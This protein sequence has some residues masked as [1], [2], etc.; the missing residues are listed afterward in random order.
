MVSAIAFVAPKPGAPFECRSVELDEVRPHEVL[1]DI[2]A[3]GIC[4]TDIAVQQGKL[5]MRLPGILGHEGAGVVRMVGSEVKDVQPGDHVV[6]SYNSCG[7]CRSCKGEKPYQC[8]NAE[9]M[10]FGGSRPDGSQTVTSDSETI[11]T[12]FFGQSSFC[13]PAIVQEASC[14]K[15]DKSLPLKVICALG[16]GFQTGTGAVYNVVDPQQRN[17]RHIAIFG[18][19]AVGCAAIMAASHL[20]TSSSAAP[21]FEIIA[22]DINDSRLELAKELGATRVIN[23]RQGTAREAIMEITNNEGLDAAVDCTGVLAVINEMIALVGPGGIAVS[24]GGPPPGI[25]ASVDVFGMIIKSKT[26]SGC[27]QGN[28]F[29]KTYIPWL[30]DLYARGQFPLQKLQK[31]YRAEE[32]NQACQDMLDGKVLKP[33]LLWD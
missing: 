19:G 29:S 6:L 11:R 31:T 24:V 12:C 23:S 30:A 16:C 33:V 18:V 10:N 25:K 26:Y 9:S 14:V 4:H 1:V 8:D 32:I 15:V 21:A 28:A 17:I 22:I 13:S 5:P 3:T 7:T 2:K 20:A 27:H